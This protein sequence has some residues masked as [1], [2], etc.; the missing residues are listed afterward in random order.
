MDDDDNELC[1]FTLVEI[2]LVIPVYSLRPRGSGTW[3]ICVAMQDTLCSLALPPLNNIPQYRGTVVYCQGLLRRRE[4]ECAGRPA[5]GPYTQPEPQHT[6]VMSNF[7]KV[8][9]LP[10]MLC[11]Y[12]GMAVR[13]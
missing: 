9:F 2:I 11:L 8:V 12:L 6:W 4:Q 10:V 1:S 5:G 3:C 7:F 13:S